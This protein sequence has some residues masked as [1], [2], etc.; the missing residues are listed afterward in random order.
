MKAQDFIV[1]FSHF[2]ASFN[3]RRGLGREFQKL[4]IKCKILL[5]N[6]IFTNTTLSPKKHHFTPRFGKN[7]T[8]DSVYSPKTHNS[9][10]S[11]KML[12]T[13][14][15]AQFYSAF[16]LTTISLTPLLKTR[17]LTTLFHQKRSTRLKTRSYE[18]D[19]KFYSAFLATTLNFAMRFWQK[20]IV[21]FEYPVEFDE[22]LQ[23][24]WLY[25]VLYLLVI[26]RCKKSYK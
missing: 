22:D 15:N 21:N 20:I 6:R 17:S 13:A 26:E 23:K 12:Y 9:N 19:A 25:C 1:S 10:S 11:L 16:S 18:D 2:L 5:H 4:F 7:A 24:C 3:N 8:F 14:E